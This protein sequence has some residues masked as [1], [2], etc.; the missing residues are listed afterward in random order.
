MVFIIEHLTTEFI[1]Y[2]LYCTT[3]HSEFQEVEI[4][5]SII[6]SWVYS[7]T[8]VCNNF[9]SFLYKEIKTEKEILT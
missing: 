5:I 8:W 2:L 9:S 1:N 6:E 7:H 4:I 3:L